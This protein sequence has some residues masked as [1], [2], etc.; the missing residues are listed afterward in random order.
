MR[1]VAFVARTAACA[2]TPMRVSAQTS[3]HLVVGTSA[4]DGGLSPLVAANGGFFKKYGLDVEVR[5]MPSGAATSAAIIGGSL[6]IGATNMLGLINA[7]AKGLPFQIIAPQGLYLSE[8]ASQ[9]IIVRKDAAIRTGGDLNGKTISSAALGDLMALATLLWIDQHGGDSSTVQR[10]ELS[11]AATLAALESGR[12]DAA[13]LTQPHL[14]EALQSGN[15]RSIG[16]VY[17]AIGKRFLLTAMITT[18]TFAGDNRDIV[19]RYAHAQIEANGY[20]NLH[21]DVTAQWLAD[22]AKVDVAVIQ[23]SPREIFAETLD[24]AMIQPAIDAAAR[25]NVIPKPFDARDLISPIVVGIH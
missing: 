13:G 17:D 20:A 2:A 12:I 25:Y 23:R 14:S 10:I 9:L 3:P 11:P 22:F 6:S 4:V 1:R 18:A 8:K 24:P 19:E 15:V 16:K 21:H 7:H 5:A